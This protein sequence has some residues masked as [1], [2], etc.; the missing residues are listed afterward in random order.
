MSKTLVYIFKIT[1]FEWEF[2]AVLNKQLENI[3]NVGF[4]YVYYQIKLSANSIVMELKI[5]DLWS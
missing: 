5:I 2:Q 4:E 3:L 1:Y